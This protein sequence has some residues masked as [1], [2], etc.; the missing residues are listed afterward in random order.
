MNTATNNESQTKVSHRQ[1]I[2]RV[3]IPES[4]LEDLKKV[5]EVRVQKLSVMLRDYLEDL[6]EDTIVFDENTDNN[7]NIY[8]PNKTF[9][10][11]QPGTVFRFGIETFT[12]LK[13]IIEKHNVTTSVAI[14]YLVDRIIIEEGGIVRPKLK[15]VPK[16]RKFLIDDSVEKPKTETPVTANMVTLTFKLG[17]H[18]K[19]QITQ[20]AKSKGVNI[21][22]LYRR[23][24]NEYTGKKY[25]ITEELIMVSARIS[26][27]DK[28]KLTELSNIYKVENAALLRSA[29]AEEIER[30]REY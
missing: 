5:G 12:K 1:E 24:I 13:R 23:A 11:R 16:Y 18:Q 26:V 22:E 21:S 29:V 20:I 9:I 28:A 27:Y 7:P 3:L 15:I 30:K 2:V 19:K 8:I 14:R 17:V 4:Q 6:D 25:D 10:E